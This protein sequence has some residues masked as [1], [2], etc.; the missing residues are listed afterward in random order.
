M[1]NL[2]NHNNQ[3]SSRKINIKKKKSHHNSRN[4]LSILFDE[5]NL[6]DEEFELIK[7]ELH[8]KHHFHLLMNRGSSCDVFNQYT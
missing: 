3:H 5:I 2:V 6:S 7:K 1:K 8:S 4:I